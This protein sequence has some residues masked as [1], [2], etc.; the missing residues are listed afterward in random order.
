MGGRMSCTIEGEP[1][2]GGCVL[3]VSL[4]ARIIPETPRPRRKNCRISRKF[5]S[6][7]NPVSCSFSKSKGTRIAVPAGHDARS[8][9]D[10][11]PS[12]PVALI[13]GSVGGRSFSSADPHTTATRLWLGNNSIR[14]TVRASQSASEHIR[15]TRALRC[16]K[17]NALRH[18]G[19]L[20]RNDSDNGTDSSDID[21]WSSAHI[22]CSFR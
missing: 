14:C 15:C 10:K 3:A 6:H 17:V 7:E 22:S 5:N 21:A 8:G 18:S 2:H 13:P 19:L 9:M 12:G 16:D 1:T 4:A 11:R 20:Y